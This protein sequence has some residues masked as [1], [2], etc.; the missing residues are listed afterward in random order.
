VGDVFDV[1][2]IPCCCGGRRTVGWE[3]EEEAFWTESGGEWHAAREQD[4]E[5]F[6]LF[7]S[8]EVF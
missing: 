7:V 8:D 6:I 5:E 1:V 2:L 3:S 4:F